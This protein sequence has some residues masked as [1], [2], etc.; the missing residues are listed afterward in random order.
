MEQQSFFARHK[1]L[2]IVGGII[3]LVVLWAG[4]L[5]NNFVTQSEVITSQWAQVENQL[6]RRFD[7]IPNLQ[8]TVQGSSQQEKDLYKQITDARARY[9]GASTIDQKAQVAG[10]FESALGR[11]LVI[12]ESNPTFQSIAQYKDFMTVLE[13]TENRLSVER[14]KYN[15]SVQV[16]NTAVK[17]FPGSLFASIFGFSEHAYFEI[18]S[19]AAQN[20]KVKFTN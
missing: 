14:K 20:P 8:A 7:L 6:Q 19:E 18:T 13:G 10:Q 2:I 1:T 17:R 3:L 11:L 5:Y 9:S 12:N 16:Y 4:S 15:D